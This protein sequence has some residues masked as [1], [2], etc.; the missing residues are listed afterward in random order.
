MQRD[1]PRKLMSGLCSSPQ[2]LLGGNMFPR[3]PAA[4][5]HALLCLAQDSLGVA[6]ARE[7]RLWR[8]V[9]WGLLPSRRYLIWD[10]RLSERNAGLNPAGKISPPRIG[11]GKMFI[12]NEEASL[13][14]AVFVHRERRSKEMNPSFVWRYCHS[15]LEY[16]IFLQHSLN[17]GKLKVSVQSAKI[18]FLPNVW[19]TEILHV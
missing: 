7:M 11:E 8:R 19:L 18:L 17:N 12:L 14:G 10:W 13:P 15:G 1:K 4:S 5:F 3:K 9:C 6:S 16:F 2:A